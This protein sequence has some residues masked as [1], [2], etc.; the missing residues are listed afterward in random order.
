MAQQTMVAQARHDRPS[1]WDRVRSG[2]SPDGLPGASPGGLVDRSPDTLP[3]T[4]PDGSPATLPDGSVGNYSP[5]GSADGFDDG[6]CLV[7]VLGDSAFVVDVDGKMAPLPEEYA[8]GLI[9]E[10]LQRPEYE[11]LHGKYV[12]VRAL[13]K[14]LYPRFLKATGREPVPW[15]SVSA[16]L[17][18]LARDGKL[19][20]MR[21]LTLRA[22][23]GR[24]R[25][26]RQFK[27]FLVPRPQ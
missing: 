25:R 23:R 11:L 27:Q 22:G 24:K 6:G 7:Q 17:G 18:R 15:R 9:G 14:K 10:Y 16:A 13:E 2:G 12:T 19:T 5:D 21:V 3:H 4:L 8:V 20:H 26:A 1:W